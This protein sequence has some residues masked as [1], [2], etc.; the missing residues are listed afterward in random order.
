MTRA[1]VW[2]GLFL[3]GVA[4]LALAWA[5]W[6]YAWGSDLS[7][8]VQSTQRNLHGKLA[9]AM[10]AVRADQT[11]ALWNLIVLGFGYGV[12]HAVGPGHGK[13]VISTYLATTE[14]GAWRGIGL[15]LASSFLQAATAI[16][17]VEVTVRLLGLALR[18]ARVGASA[19]ETAS[20]VLLALVG[21]GLVV[22]AARR[23]WRRRSAAAHDHHDHGTD[24]GHAHG[25]DAARLAAPMNW[26]QA[27]SIVLAVGLR[28][29]SGA[30]L[31]LLFA[32][33]LNLGLVGVA[34]ALA[35]SAGTA[36]TVAGLALLAVHG[37]RAAL[38]FGRRAG[39]AAGRLAL[40]VDLAAVVGGLVIVMIGLSLF[41]GAFGAIR[42]PLL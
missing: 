34:A 41:L 17:V 25:P 16:A 32:K 10:R 28:P 1:R 40:G 18:D 19:I 29:C 4:G 37:R 3:C 21:L 33:I 14:A 36:V 22:G 39:W 23:A 5:A 27:A 30:V 42:H 38:F 12:F 24:H 2:G 31:V 11:A 6:R 7:A 9:E 8:F 35:I 15:T 13:F 20:Y 26:G